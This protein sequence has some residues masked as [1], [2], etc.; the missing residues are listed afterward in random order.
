MSDG[1]GPADQPGLVRGHCGRGSSPLARCCGRLRRLNLQLSASYGFLLLLS[2]GLTGER[3]EAD[4]RGGDQEDGSRGSRITK[5]ELAA[6]APSGGPC[7]SGRPHLG[8]HAARAI[9]P[10]SEGATRRSAAL[11][12][13]SSRRASRRSAQLQ[14]GAASGAPPPWRKGRPVSECGLSAMRLR[15]VCDDDANV[16][17]YRMRAMSIEPRS[18]PCV[19]RDRKR[20]ERG[21]WRSPNHPF[22]RWSG[23]DGFALERAGDPSNAV[24][25]AKPL[26][27]CGV[28]LR[29]S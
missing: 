6:R 12:A 19:T 3:I 2:A 29:S 4:E 25:E 5:R 27:P 17:G 7:A 20:G 22:L 13:R 21:A 26:S 23:A 16:K 1:A 24:R 9:G 18:R 10:R 28:S 15:C 8:P 11:R 14:S